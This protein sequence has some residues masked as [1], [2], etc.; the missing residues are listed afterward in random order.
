M[1]RYDHLHVFKDTYQLNLYFFNLSR[2]F[3]KD[4]KYGLGQEV[5]GLLTELLDQIIIA[6]SA[7][8]KQPTLRDASLTIERIKFKIRILKDLKV[9]K[10]A[11][12]QHFSKLLIDISKQI[13]KWYG[14]SKSRTAA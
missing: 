2:G 13:E 9:M 5:R 3:P 10:I 14:W 7:K 11:S 4:F 6:N 12:Y 1:A 8:E